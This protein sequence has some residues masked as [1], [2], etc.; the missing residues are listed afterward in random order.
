MKL[1][2]NSC[3]PVLEVDVGLPHVLL[4]EPDR[5]ILRAQ[6]PRVLGARYLLNREQPAGLLLMQPEN[7]DFNVS[8]F[9]E[10]RVLCA[11]PMAELASM[12]IQTLASGTP[13]ALRRVAMPSPSA[14][15]R[16]T[17]YS[18]DSPELLA[19][20]DCILE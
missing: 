14:D 16:T 13:K 12:P 7:V 15:A 4:Q 5:N 17:A 9:V 18:S 11:M 2:G 20:V 8:D 1:L 19:M 6:I 3:S 10:A